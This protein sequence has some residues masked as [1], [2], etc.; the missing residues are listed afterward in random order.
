LKLLDFETNGY[1]LV[2]YQSSKLPREVLAASQAIIVTR[3]SDP[4]E[5]RALFGL[6]ESC[7]GRKSESEWAQLLGG[8]TIGEAVVLPITEEAQGEARRIRLTPRLTP[9]VR[10]LAKYIDIPV[11]DARAFVFSPGGANS[12]RR[13][14]TLREFVESVEILPLEVLDGHLRRGDFSRWM[15]EV[16][17]DYP[18]GKAVREIEEDYRR[19]RVRS[20]ATNLA[21]AV[22]SRY[23]FLDPVPR[24][25]RPTSDEP[26]EVG[27]PA[28]S[29]VLPQSEALQLH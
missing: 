15:T 1:T 2:S 16:F 29:A 26:A 12:G 27:A 11:Q 10:H 19:G 8:L 9:H 18:L 17:G 14:R 25:V 20:V 6:C 3:E 13:A 24:N 21:L 5:V 23:E 28:T 4:S 22:R 7:G